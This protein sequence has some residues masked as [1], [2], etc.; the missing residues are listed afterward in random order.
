MFKCQ[1]CQKEIIV[2]PA[3]KNRIN[4]SRASWFNQLGGL[5]FF[6]SL[7]F[8]SLEIKVKEETELALKPFKQ[9]QEETEKNKEIK[10]SKPAKAKEGKDKKED[11]KND[12]GQKSGKEGDFRV[13]MW[14]TLRNEIIASE[15]SAK[16]EVRNDPYNLDYLTKIAEHQVVAHYMFAQNRLSGGCYILI[17]Q[18]LE[19]HDEL[20]KKTKLKVGETCPSWIKLDLSYYSEFSSQVLNSVAATEKFFYEMYLSL[21]SQMGPP[22]DTA[23]E[24][25]ENQISR[26][27]KIESVIAYSRMLTYSWETTRSKINFYFGCLDSRPYFRLEFLSLKEAMKEKP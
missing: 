19:N 1:I 2:C 12:K 3:C 25:L 22:A 21:A 16:I 6:F 9:A 13:G 18:P 11:D 26:Q 17:G 15:K 10:E 7:I 14:G 20:R 8:V 27:E 5:F 23:L 24:E 4:D